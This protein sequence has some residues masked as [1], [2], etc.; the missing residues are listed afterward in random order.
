MWNVLS[1]V[2][3]NMQPF[4]FCSKKLVHFYGNFI[5]CG[6]GC[7][8]IWN[9]SMGVSTCIKGCNGLVFRSWNF[10]EQW[11]LEILSQVALLWCR[12]CMSNVVRRNVALFAFACCICFCSSETCLQM[13]LNLVFIKASSRF[14]LTWQ[15]SYYKITGSGW[16]GGC[17][18][19]NR[20]PGLTCSAW[21]V[22][23]FRLLNLHVCKLLHLVLQWSCHVKHPRRTLMLIQAWSCWMASSSDGAMQ[24]F[25]PSASDHTASSCHC[26]VIRQAFLPSPFPPSLQL[27]PHFHFLSPRTAALRKAAQT[28]SLQENLRGIRCRLGGCGVIH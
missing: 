14:L 7:V 1:N 11:V 23:Y 20:N 2:K 13:G 5:C 4:C 8:E 3:E 24:C 17:I 16:G 6:I 25:H 21:P 10:F 28:A 15:I 26:S 27:L 12:N 18:M 9:L 22:A 19:K